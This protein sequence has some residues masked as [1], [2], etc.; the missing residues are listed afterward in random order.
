MKFSDYFSAINVY[1]LPEDAKLPP[2][3]IHPTLTRPKS[4]KIRFFWIIVDV[5]P[6]MIIWLNAQKFSLH[7]SEN[8]AIILAVMLVINKYSPRQ[9]YRIYCL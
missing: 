4:L 5:E 2:S 7:F 9:R 6:K 8:C 1:R 3:P